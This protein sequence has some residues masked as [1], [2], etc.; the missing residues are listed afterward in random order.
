MTS[1]NTMVVIAPLALVLAVA[2]TVLAFI[3]ILPEKRRAKLPAIF[4]FVS[5]VFQFKFLIVEK[6]FQALY[7]LSTLFCVIYGVLSLFGFR[8]YEF[9]GNS[10]VYWYGGYGLLTLIIGPIIVRFMYELMMM[11]ILLIKNVIQIN[12]KLKNQNG[13]DT[14]DQFSG[15]DTTELKQAFANR[16]KKQAPVAPQYQNPYQQNP[17]YQPNPYQQAPNAAVPPV[18]NNNYYGQ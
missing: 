10:D 12:N 9:Y 4:R 8:Y 14:K 11:G 17:A 6:I 15:Y 7:I 2:A 3:F 16:P 1:F 18:P 13:D 5:D